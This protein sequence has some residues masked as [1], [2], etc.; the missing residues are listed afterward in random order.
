MAQ[1]VE[2]LLRESGNHRMLPLERRCRGWYLDQGFKGA[3][4]FGAER[5][6]GCEGSLQKLAS[7]VSSFPEG[8]HGVAVA[9]T[10]GSS[11]TGKT[12]YCSVAL[13][14]DLLSAFVP[15]GTFE[16]YIPLAITFNDEWGASPFGVEGLTVRLLVTWFLGLC[17]K[18]TFLAA[19]N[20]LLPFVSGSGLTF[21]QV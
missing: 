7:Y 15:P 19:V 9:F 21:A 20:A 1:Y 13:R 2:K 11:G 6:V 5:T 12:H 16:R 10:A 17:D 3:F 18:N 4:V 8:R 14:P